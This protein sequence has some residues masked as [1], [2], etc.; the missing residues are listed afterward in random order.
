MITTKNRKNDAK[1]AGRGHPRQV[2]VTAKTQSGG[3]QGRQSQTTQGLEVDFTIADMLFT[4]L[5][6]Q[7]NLLLPLGKSCFLLGG[8]FV[9]AVRAT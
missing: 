6:C 3:H 9:M 2:H 7:L 4:A 5:F 8:D 1:Q